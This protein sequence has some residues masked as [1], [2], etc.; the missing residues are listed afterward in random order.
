MAFDNYDSTD[1]TIKKFFLI[2]YLELGWI[3]H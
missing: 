3:V 2:Y 1:Q